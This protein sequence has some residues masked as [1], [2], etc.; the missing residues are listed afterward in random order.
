MKE[1]IGFTV[2]KYY[3]NLD[4]GVD[5][6]ISAFGWTREIKMSQMCHKWQFQWKNG[7]EFH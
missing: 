4:G 1:E 6:T 2:N 3:E 7:G 5:G